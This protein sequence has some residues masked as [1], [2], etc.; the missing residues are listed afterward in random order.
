MSGDLVPRHRRRS[1]GPDGVTAQSSSTFRTLAPIATVD[2]TVFPSGGL[3]VGVAQPIVIRFNH[4][5]D[6]MSARARRFCATSPSPS[7]DRFRA[8]GTG[9]ATNELHFRPEG[10]LAEGREG[11]GGR[12]PRRLERRAN[13][14][15]GQGEVV[16]QFSIGDAHVARSPNLATHRM[17]VTDNGRVIA[18]FPLS[19]GKPADPTMNGVHIVLDRES[20]VRM[21]SSTNGIP[22]NSPDGYDELVYATCT[23]AT[24]ASTCTRRR[25]RSRARAGRTSRTVASTSARR[26]RSTF[27]GFSRVGDV[28]MVVGGPRPP[29]ARRSRGHGLGHPL[30]PV[31]TCDGP[32]H[33]RTAAADSPRGRIRSARGHGEESR[34]HAVDHGMCPEGDVSELAELCIELVGTDIM[35]TREP[36]RS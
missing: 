14:L 17:T 15:W 36:D 23:S 16:A 28:V 2:A 6:D 34:H 11:H 30:E 1:S 8:V 29:G 31:D 19:G 35:R 27:F 5:I 22:V 3:S 32:R 12:R 25:G 20:V 33:C 26:T 7:R 21:V 18:T 9:S 24:A 13:G 10:V 4:Y